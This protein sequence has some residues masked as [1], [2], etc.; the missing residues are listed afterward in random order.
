MTNLTA[1]FYGSS[2]AP[3]A[4]YLYNGSTLLSAVSAST[5]EASQSV[6]FNN[7]TDPITSGTT[8][9]FTLRADFPSN[10]ATGTIASTTLNTI[11]YTTSGGQ[12]TMS[13]NQNLIGNAQAF[14][15]ASSNLKIINT[16]TVA[17]QINSNTSSTTSMTGTFP[18]SVT[19]EPGQEGQPVTG[20]FVVYVSSSTAI[21]GNSVAVPSTGLALSPFS[22]A[23]SNSSSP[24][25]QGTT[26]TFNL[27]A[28]EQVSSLAASGYYYFILSRASTTVQNIN[29]TAVQQFYYS[30]TTPNSTSNQ[31]YVQ[32]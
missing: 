20:D 16:P 4:V 15:S 7:F 21:T 9:V 11:T 29:G 8:K 14:Y 12:I 3:T 19:P 25:S 5:T 2:T 18:I 26:Y 32:K 13:P 17:S 22:P 6:T 31:Q 23:V 1:T 10:T 30:T 28:T 27:T 24:L